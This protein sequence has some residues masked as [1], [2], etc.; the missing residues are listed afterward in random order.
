MSADSADDKAFSLLILTMHEFKQFVDDS[1][2][3]L[4]VS[5]E[6]AWVLANNIH[7]IRG[8]DGLVVLPSLLLT[9]TQQILKITKTLFR[10]KHLE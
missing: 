3:E 4:P 6:E 9:Q 7:D 2:E 5:S 8:N 10:F 1:F